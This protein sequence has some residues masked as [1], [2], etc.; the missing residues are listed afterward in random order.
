MARAIQGVHVSLQD[1][2]TNGEHDM[3]QTVMISDALYA[4]LDAS[5]HLHGMASIEQL[6]EA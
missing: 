6:L 1:E 2:P 5:A 3:S 4:R